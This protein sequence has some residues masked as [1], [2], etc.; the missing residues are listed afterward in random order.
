MTSDSRA[1]RDGDDVIRGLFIHDGARVVVRPFE[2][3]QR[4]GPYRL[5]SSRKVE[6]GLGV[7]EETPMSH[8]AHPA[9]VAL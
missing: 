8:S 7:G 9:R 5:L 4:A 1:A 3:E 6:H 2:D